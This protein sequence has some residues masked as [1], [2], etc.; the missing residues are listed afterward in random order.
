MGDG[1][2]A[3]TGAATV[4]RA[5]GR[6]V[7]TLGSFD[8][9]HIYADNGTYT[10]TVTVTAAPSPPPPTTSNNPPPASPTGRGPTCCRCAAP[11]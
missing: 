4:D 7:L 2:A 1:T 3:D 10:A 6:G 5:G 9:K 8:G 11:A